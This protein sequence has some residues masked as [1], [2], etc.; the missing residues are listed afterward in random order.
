MRVGWWIGLAAVVIVVIAIWPILF[1]L[2]SPVL[3][4]ADPISSSPGPCCWNGSGLSGTASFGAATY[5]S[6]PSNASWYW[7]TRMGVLDPWNSS[8]MSY[9]NASPFRWIRYATF[10]G[11]TADNSN[12]TAGLTYSNSGVSSA[13]GVNWT[14]VKNFLAQ[15]HSHWIFAVNGQVNNAG[16]AANEVSYIEGLGL[17]PDLWSI[18]NEPNTYTHW[19]KAMTS[20]LSGDHKAPTQAQWTTEV[21]NYTA[22]MRGVDPSIQIVGVQADTAFDKIGGWV[23]ATA[24]ST[25]ASTKIAGYGMHLYPLRQGS[26][27]FTAAQFLSPSNFS[28]LSEGLNWSHTNLTASCSACSSEPL[29]L[30]ELN[31]F[32]QNS[33]ADGR[34]Q[35]GFAEGVWVAAATIVTLRANASQVAFSAFVGTSGL[36]NLS[37]IN[38]TSGLP[39]PAYNVYTSLLGKMPIG[40][41]FDFGLT[42]SIGGIYSL[43]ERTSSTPSLLVVN[44]NTT[45]GLSLNL[46]DGAFPY[47]SPAT[48]YYCDPNTQLP[49]PRVYSAGALPQTITLAP[50]SVLLLVG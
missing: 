25:G 16:L 23:G 41:A 29:L 39:L 48:V 21:G 34:F 11:A 7:A 3:G 28:Q 42:A 46:Q 12:W 24:A 4:G 19:N 13:I 40:S 27:P 1:A 6:T 18:G 10:N 36:Q 31:S 38:F 44:T 33:A 47:T 9:V 14:H 30:D 50:E 43:L 17:H 45:R 32:S 35:V 37:L 22:A 5:V 20:W 15:T 2:P 8:L 49:L 26:Q